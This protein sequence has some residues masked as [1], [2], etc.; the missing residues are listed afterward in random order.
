MQ[1]ASTSAAPEYRKDMPGQLI[2]TNRQILKEEVMADLEDG[3]RNFLFDFKGTLHID[4]SGMGVLVSLRKEIEKRNGSLH[5][6]NLNEH[7]R[8]QFRLTKLDQ[9]FRIVN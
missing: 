7:L 3:K 4:P 5:L 1:G 9:L 8:T 6:A 2:L